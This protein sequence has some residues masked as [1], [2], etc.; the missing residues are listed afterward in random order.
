VY[1]YYAVSENRWTVYES[2]LECQTRVV[3]YLVSTLKPAWLTINH[4]RRDERSRPGR[5][6]VSD[7]RLE[8][9][10]NERFSEKEEKIGPVKDL[11]GMHIEWDLP[12]QLSRGSSC[13]NGKQYFVRVLWRSICQ[14]PQLAVCLAYTPSQAQVEASHVLHRPPTIAPG[15]TEETIRPFYGRQVPQSLSFAPSV[16]MYWMSDYC[17]EIYLARPRPATSCFWDGI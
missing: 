17:L 9:E 15:N 4:R 2:H 16:D 8:S 1:H 7:I 14:W 10:K 5:L 11:K 12:C 13:L 3:R 6:G